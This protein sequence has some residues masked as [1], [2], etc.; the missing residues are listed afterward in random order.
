MIRIRRRLGSR[1]SDASCR[2]DSSE[3]VAFLAAHAVEGA[4]GVDGL[5]GDDERP[6]APLPGIAV[7]SRGEPG[8]RPAPGVSRG[9][10]SG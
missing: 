8:P 7:S 1:L 9:R 6:L 4:A 2:V 3:A 5:A 10:I